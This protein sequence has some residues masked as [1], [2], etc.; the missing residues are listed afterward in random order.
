M[1]MKH[2]K[3][4]EWEQKLRDMSGEEFDK[5]MC[6]T[7]SS[8]FKLRTRQE[9]QE[10][11][12]PMNFG[13][14][15]GP[16]WR[17]ILDTLCRQLKVLEDQ[18]GLI[19]V[20]DQIKEKF[21]SGRF[22]HHVEMADW[23]KKEYEQHKILGKGGEEELDKVDKVVMEIID[24]LASHFEE[25]TCYVCEELG[26]NVRPAEKISVGSWMYG[27]GL[28][29]FKHWTLNQHCK[30]DPEAAQKRIEAAEKFLERAKVKEDIKD[31]LYRLGADDICELRDIMDAKISE[32]AKKHDYKQMIFSF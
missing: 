2:Y 16:G 20:F 4:N 15:V 7:Y 1:W 30:N 6:E 5:Y 22:Y 3:L 18:Y 26:T 32:R 31:G 10:I 17:H 27:M 24:V 9:G 14:C 12:L 25:Y 28:E 21:G 19:C 11:I 29:G 8:M 13:F 23:K